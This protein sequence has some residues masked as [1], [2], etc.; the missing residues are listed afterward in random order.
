MEL[1][2]IRTEWIDIAKALGIITVLFFTLFQMV[3]I[4][5]SCTTTARISDYWWTVFYVIVGLVGSLLMRKVAYHV[6]SRLTKLIY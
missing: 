6:K 2:K 1:T 4:E 3:T 5:I